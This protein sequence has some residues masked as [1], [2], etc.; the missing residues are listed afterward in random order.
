MQFPG[1]FLQLC[2]YRSVL[3]S[4]FVS[5]NLYPE[6]D[7]AKYRNGKKNNTA[8]KPY[9]C[10]NVQHGNGFSFLFLYGYFCCHLFRYFNYYPLFWC[11]YHRAVCGFLLHGGSRG[12]HT[13]YETH[14]TASV[15]RNQ[16]PE[17]N[18]NPDITA[19]S[20]GIPFSE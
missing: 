20:A 4:C 11:I 5:G 16:Q 10:G 2:L 17:C 12:C 8:R 9:I 1:Q 13:L 19:P 18:E 6:I 14:N 3:H 15:Y 7:A